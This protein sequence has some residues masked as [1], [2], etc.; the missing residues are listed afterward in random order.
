[1][2]KWKM[3]RLGDVATYVNGF[4]FKPSDWAK[5]G[6]P[7]IRI[8]NLTGNDYETNRYPGEY[9]KK[10]EVNK[11]D[12]LISW[13]ASLGVFE[14]EKDTALLNQHIFKVVFDKIIVDKKYFVFVVG[15]TIKSM[16]KYTH[17]STMKHIVKSDF[18]NIQIPLPPLEIQQKI[19]VV[20]D[21]ASALIELRKTQLSKLDLLIKSQFIEMF[22]DPVINPKGWPFESLGNLGD[23]NRGVSKHRP[24]ND[25]ELLDGPYPLIQT[26][27]VSRADLYITDY[28]STYSEIGLAQS[29]MWPKGTLCITIAANIA[30]TA[31]LPFDA[32]FPDSVV[33]FISGEKTSQIYIHYWFGFF[34]KILEEQAPQVA[35]KNINLQ[36]LNN[37]NVTVPPIELQKQFTSFV[38]QVE[39]SKLAIQQSLTKLELNYKSLMQKCFRGEIF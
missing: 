23:L 5:E 14:W 21:N 33:G 32:C 3:V 26:G 35:Q 31:I 4:A 12:I 22:G 1:M 8:Q 15:D 11:G 2:G 25:S 36:I 29:R 30:Q 37:L 28:T 9:D 18:S 7:I 34:Q 10:Y 20:L 19:A 6:L 16:L 39:K 17:G 24:R 13:S 38:Q 27:E